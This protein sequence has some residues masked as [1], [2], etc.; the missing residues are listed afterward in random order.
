M[1]YIQ[2][3][4]SFTAVISIPGSSSGDTVT[5]AIYKAS[6]KSTFASGSM[7]FVADEMWKVSFTP[8][9]LDVYILKVVD[10]T[11]DS[12]RENVYQAIGAEP[13]VDTEPS[14]ADLT[15]LAN[16]RAFLKK[17]ANDTADDS[18]LSSIIARVSAD[19]AKRCNR[20]F[21][22]G[23]VTEYYKGNNKSEMLVRRPPVNSV[24]SIHVDSDRVWGS[25]T[26]IDADS[27]VIAEEC[28]G[29]IT[30][31]DETFDSYGNVENVKI[32]YNGG[33]STIPADLESKV[34]RLCAWDYLEAS[35]WNNT[36][37]KGEK[38][39][40]ELRDAV[41]KEILNNYKLRT[42]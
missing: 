13:L 31:I 30:L 9:A 17:Q 40:D 24:T 7:T 41:W 4:K 26:A 29:L 39:I 42:F 1:D 28:P 16:L 20:T 21:A 12:K 2:L 19:V 32:V 14:G 33:Y 15:T 34:L 36:V 11:I 35:R 5:Y 37:I 18:L 27:I 10:S 25:D 38:N 8:T 3:N 6:D 22:A 23:A